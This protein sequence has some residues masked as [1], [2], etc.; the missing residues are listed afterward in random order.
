MRGFHSVL[1]QLTLLTHCP[2]H[3]K[4]RL[5]ERCQTCNTRLRY[6]L[7]I[8]TLEHP[9]QCTQCRRRFSRSL[10]GMLQAEDQ[11]N[12]RTVPA[13]ERAYLRYGFPL[14]DYPGRRTVKP[15]TPRFVSRDVVRALQEG[16]NTLSD[17][18][19]KVLAQQT[20]YDSCSF[21]SDVPQP[22]DYQKKMI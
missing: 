20:G 4:T 6:E 14:M 22:L 11:P 2:I 1:F 19:W 10:I 21:T 7:N 8:L 17:E 15:Y 16:Q 5:I 3:K 18:Q 13:F 12:D 9:Y